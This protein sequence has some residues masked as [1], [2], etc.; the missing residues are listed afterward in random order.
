MR[1]TILGLVLVVLGAVALWL[2][3]IPYTDTEVFELGPIEATTEVERR[4][5]IPPILA[6]TVMALGVGLVVYAKGHR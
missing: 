6:G 1:L 4:F 3:G 5:E 2:G